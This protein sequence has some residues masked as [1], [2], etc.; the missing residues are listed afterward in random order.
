M[1]PLPS[2]PA[3]ELFSAD[4]HP[5]LDLPGFFPGAGG[6]FRGHSNKEKKR[7]LFWQAHPASSKAKAIEHLATWVSTAV[8][9]AERQLL[10]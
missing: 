7:F 5:N 9:D 3:N 6:F 10:S 2:Y 1:T 4:F 8:A